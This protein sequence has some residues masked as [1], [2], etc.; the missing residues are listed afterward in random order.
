M[1]PAVLILAGGEGRRI[2]GDKPLRLLGGR[3]LIDRAIERAERWSD[4]IA[5]A[6]RSAD[7][8]GETRFPVLID[9]LGLE[10][11]LGGLASALRLERPVVLTIPC[12]MPFLP[13]DVPDRLAEAL[14]GHGA[15]LAASE[16][17]L[18]PVCGLWR[19][20]A[21]ARLPAYAAS[22]RRSLIGFA[23]TVGYAAV[24]WSGDPFFNVN[25]RQDL[26]QA[27]ARLAGL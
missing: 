26:E 2:G 7:Q 3:T 15:A 27:G 13:D 5:I 14:Q 17:R 19:A 23:E 22:G 12:D 16:G 25:S 18:H 6:A 21:L 9:P 10:G 11:P 8:V 1:K 20:E 24:E 4:R